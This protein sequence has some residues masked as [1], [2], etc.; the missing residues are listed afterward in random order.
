[1]CSI[2]CQVLKEDFLFAIGNFEMGKSYLDNTYKNDFY[3]IT[4][5]TTKISLTFNAYTNQN[6]S[7]INLIDYGEFWFYKICD[8]DIIVIDNKDLIFTVEFLNGTTKDIVVNINEVFKIRKDR[9]TKLSV[10]F[11]FSQQDVLNLLIIDKGFGEFY[12]P[13][14]KRFNESYTLV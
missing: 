3:A 10:R 4:D 1:M 6:I 14:N 11:D 13:I 9:T 8:F 7:N 12:E 2:G 5:S